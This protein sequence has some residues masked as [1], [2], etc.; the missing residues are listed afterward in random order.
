MQR[1]THGLDGFNRFSLQQ[2]VA[3]LIWPGNADRHT[4]LQE[5]VG[6][7]ALAPDGAA[8]RD[9]EASD[10]EEWLA[11]AGAN[12]LQGIQPDG[13]HDAP[14]AVHAT[15]LGQRRALLGARLG[16]PTI[17]YQLWME[18][19]HGIADSDL[20]GALL[21]LLA[22]SSICDQVVERAGLGAT[23]WPHHKGPGAPVAAPSRGGVR[24]STRRPAHHRRR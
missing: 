16:H 13:I 1:L 5:L 21:L 7:L 2:G 18:S 22:A 19:L 14:L 23:R 17:H 12:A 9:I 4:A 8:G 6:A 24:T 3:A 15:F 11:G 20:E 10:W